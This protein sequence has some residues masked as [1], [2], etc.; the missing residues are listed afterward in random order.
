MADKED[1]YNLPVPKDIVPVN[2]NDTS[3]NPS[4]ILQGTER[5]SPE[6][7]RAYMAAR[8]DNPEWFDWV[9]ELNTAEYS[10]NIRKLFGRG[11]DGKS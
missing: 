7:V 8:T 10:S 11:Q 9:D 5:M 2:A 6:Q 4:A 3:L 1:I